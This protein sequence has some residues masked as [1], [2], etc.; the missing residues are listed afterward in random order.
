MGGQAPTSVLLREFCPIHIHLLPKQ[1]GVQLVLAKA[2]TGPP[3]LPFRNISSFSVGCTPW[4]MPPSSCGAAQH[5]TR[6]RSV[7]LTDDFSQQLTP[8]L[9]RVRSCRAPK[10]DGDTADGRLRLISRPLATN[11]PVARGSLEALPLIW[12]PG[13]CLIQISDRLS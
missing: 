6:S 4:D 1:T 10:I 3:L 11:R 2:R 12:P 13:N 9:E 8:G 7:P 5:P